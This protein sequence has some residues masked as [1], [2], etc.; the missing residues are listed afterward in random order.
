V[1]TLKDV[2]VA[3]LFPAQQ[4][5]LRRKVLELLELDPA[6]YTIEGGVVSIDLQGRG[7]HEETVG[8]GLQFDVKLKGQELGT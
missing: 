2:S 7:D 5:E 8:L 1:K 4:E 3:S 6:T